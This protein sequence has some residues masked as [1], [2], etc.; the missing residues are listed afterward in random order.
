MDQDIC[1]VRLTIALP[2]RYVDL[3]TCTFKKASQ[4]LQGLPCS[5]PEDGNLVCEH[6][7]VASGNYHRR[8]LEKQATACFV[9]WSFDQELI[10]DCHTQNEY[11]SSEA[12]ASSTKLPDLPEIQG[13]WVTLTTMLCLCSEK[14]CN[15]FLNWKKFFTEE[16]DNGS[17]R[18][19]NGSE[20]IHK[21]IFGLDINMTG[22]SSVDDKEDRVACLL[23]RY[24][25][26]DT[27]PVYLE[28]LPHATSTLLDRPESRVVLGICLLV[29]TIMKLVAAC[30]YY[31]LWNRRR[32]PAAD[33]GAEHLMHP[34]A[35]QL[36]QFFLP[37]MSST[38]ENDL[39]MRLQADATTPHMENSSLNNLLMLESFAQS[40]SP[41][42][43]IMEAA[44][45]SQPL[46]NVP[47]P[48]RNRYGRPY[49]S[50]RP[51][52][53]C[54]RQKIV[55]LFENGMKKIHIAKQLG[56]THSC[57]SKVL[58]K[59][60]DTG[61]VEARACRTASCS[62]PG[63]APSHDAKLCRHIRTKRLLF[64]IENILRTDAG[65]VIYFSK[66]KDES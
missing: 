37:R 21:E 42:N 51:L 3:P 62:C 11:V 61:M 33:G 13:C 24:L 41:R 55:Q 14:N 54:D 65:S 63:Y 31:H 22:L 48:S 34:A 19:L 26:T 58:R 1:I 59:Y 32:W 46:L 40:L 60:Q 5:F 20:S 25:D 2:V 4:L 50:G 39:A 29:M 23:K 53:T 27:D 44:V 47:Y 45:P 16:L 10:T 28:R 64:S 49:I 7:Y 43:P 66:A 12:F 36:Q 18:S 56:I 52:L 6:G 38:Y 9:A 17:L 8:Q 30:Y 15:N 57:V 35:A